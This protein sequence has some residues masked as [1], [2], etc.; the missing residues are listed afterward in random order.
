M[1]VWDRNKAI[2]IESCRFVEMVGLKYFIVCVYI[3]NIHT[4]V[5][6]HI[7]I[8]TYV[9]IYIYLHKHIHIGL[10]CLHTYNNICAMNKEEAQHYGV[11]KQAVG[12]AGV[13]VWLQ[14]QWEGYIAE[15]T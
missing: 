1:I 12:G 6:V 15:N 3:T 13:A 5:P 10:V 11:S 2:D 14:G 4:H 7:Y 8:Y 9:Y